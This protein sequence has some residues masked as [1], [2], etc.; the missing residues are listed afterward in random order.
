MARSIRRQRAR[1]WADIGEI[2]PGSWPA[3]RRIGQS[4]R[5]KEQNAAARAMAAIDY[6]Q[7]VKT[8][9]AP[10]DFSPDQR[11]RGA[12]SRKPRAGAGRSGGVAGRRPQPP[13]IMNEYAGMLD[14]A[15]LTVAGE[16]TPSGSSML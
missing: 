2:N 10:I 7:A 6:G 5:S 8:I 4:A 12:G 1:C 15:Q 14:V 9:L 16:R 3:A 11:G 13:V